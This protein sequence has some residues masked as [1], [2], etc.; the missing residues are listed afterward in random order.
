MSNERKTSG[1]ILSE[2]IIKHPILDENNKICI[3][4]DTAIEAMETYAN[5]QKQQFIS[6]INNR[7]KELEEKKSTFNKESE[8][9]M[10]DLMIY[11]NN[12][13]LTTITN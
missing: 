5:Q 2:Y 1:E 7:I 6:V 3:Q 4:A 11:E 13:I 9:T 8:R 10:I 12:K